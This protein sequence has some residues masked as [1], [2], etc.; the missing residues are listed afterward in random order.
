MGNNRRPLPIGSPIPRVP[1]LEHVHD[2]KLDL[3]ARERALGMRVAAGAHGDVGV[4]AS[5]QY[6]S[7]WQISCVGNSNGPY[8]GFQEPWLP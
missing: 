4:A 5:G 7:S 3:G 2:N 8:I 1:A 6:S